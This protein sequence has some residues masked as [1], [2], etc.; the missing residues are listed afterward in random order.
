MKRVLV[1]LIAAVVLATTHA[2]AA[3]LLPYKAPPPSPAAPATW[4]GFYV[5]LNGGYGVGRDP[6]SQA[7]TEPGVGSAFSLSNQWVSP[8]GGLFGGQL[9]YNWQS[10]H[11]LFGAEGD[12]QWAG[13]K[14]TA[15]CNITC[16]GATTV[17]PG[18]FLVGSVE[19][20]LDW[21]GTV[22]GR[23]GW[24]TDSWLLYVTGGG[25]WGRVDSTTSASSTG[26]FGF[27]AFALFNPFTVAES[28]S[29]TKGGWV[30]GGGTEVRLASSWSAKFEYLYMDL[31][32]INDVLP[33]T[34]STA[35]LTTSSAIRDNI[36]R[37]GVNYKF[38]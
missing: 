32:S 18:G 2:F 7:L 26:A 33:I 20:K 10:G 21:F 27:G 25:A 36:V 3:D 15:G 13:Q 12:I 4:T 11:V 29:F 14:D 19:Q 9:G 38:K 34:G 24:A 8:L 23:V 1:G 17:P 5:G 31:G 22:R 16:F 30:I 37:A 35:I 28:S 6:I